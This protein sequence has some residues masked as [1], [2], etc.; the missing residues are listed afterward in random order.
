MD[1]PKEPAEASDAGY[2]PTPIESNTTRFAMLLVLVFGL[3]GV[4]LAVIDR[5]SLHLI[6]QRHELVEQ[7]CGVQTS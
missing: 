5:Q 7:Y 4:A 1:T 6:A 2:S 3:L